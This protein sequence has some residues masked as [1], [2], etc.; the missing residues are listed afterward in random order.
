[1][2]WSSWR[3][4]CRSGEVHSCSLA[5]ILDHVTA[6]RSGR[7]WAIAL[8]LLFACHEGAETT[9]PPSATFARLCEVR[10]PVE[11]LPLA[12][13]ES[14]R[15]G[16]IAHRY[17][18]RLVFSVETPATEG[19]PLAR[20]SVRS[21]G[22][23][24]EEPLV[25]LEDVA[26]LHAHAGFAHPVACDRDGRAWLLPA[27]GEAPQ[28]L[29]ED[30][31]C[32]VWPA[33]SGAVGLRLQPAGA[34]ASVLLR[35]RLEDGGTEVLVDSIRGPQRL[36]SDP[37]AVAGTEVFF[38]DRDDRLV[39]L[40]TTE[41]STTI[42]AEDVGGFA[43][44]ADGRFV[45]WQGVEPFT[46][47]LESYPIALIDRDTGERIEL[48]WG[49]LAADSVTLADGFASAFADPA[50]GGSRIVLL[51]EL[52]SFLP[53]A[54]RR[55]VARLSDDLLSM[56]VHT[57]QIGASLV[58]HDVN[59]RVDVASFFAGVAIVEQGAGFDVLTRPEPN[60]YDLWHW[61]PRD[62]PPRFVTRVG[63]GGYWRVSDHQIVVSSA[64]ARAGDLMVVDSTTGDE[65]RVDR[66]AWLGGRA[67]SKPG[68]LGPGALLYEVFAPGRTGVW[69]A[70]L[71]PM[72]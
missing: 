46:V 54:G 59:E 63:G 28:V 23:C 45:A 42:L 24:G 8:G 68:P 1:M 36:A 7:P 67:N 55:A 30:T 60:A 2:H 22:L 69:A 53:G 40:E 66:D 3:V 4:Q 71:E 44:S 35:P 57:E 61:T 16:P 39:A 26:A 20:V 41:R 10:R 9:E 27:T 48:G 38:V 62:G 32:A 19:H 21:T 43:V 34:T 17:D 5:A 13:G 33:G 15:S 18:D 72:K 64:S 31:G 56:Q 70:R 37:L 50:Q 12:E 58:V 14:I 49:S 25:L 6:R 29:F 65:H 51:P 52:T 47:G 11:I